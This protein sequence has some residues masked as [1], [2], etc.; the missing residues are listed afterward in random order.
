MVVEVCNRHR[1]VVVVHNSRKL[2]AVRHDNVMVDTS[3]EWSKAV[4]DQNHSA[5]RA[6]TRARV[7]EHVVRFLELQK[8]LADLENITVHF[9]HAYHQRLSRLRDQESNLPHSRVP[10]RGAERASVPSQ[11][12]E[13][14]R[15]AATR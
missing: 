8:C 15:A 13:A 11:D 3:G 7:G 5:S 10:A 6:A 9:L 1:G 2:E 4:V 14:F 12:T